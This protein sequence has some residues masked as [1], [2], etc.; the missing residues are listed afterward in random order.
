M[1]GGNGAVLVS[2]DGGA[3]WEALNKDI[4]TAAGIT[5]AKS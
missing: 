4:I 1:T 3:T 5:A 2:H